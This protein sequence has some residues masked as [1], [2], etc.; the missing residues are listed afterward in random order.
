MHPSE[1]IRGA[2]SD[3]LA[4]MSIVIGITGSIAAVECVKLIRE[5][6][7]HGAIVRAVMTPWAERIVGRDAIEF[8]TGEPV[9]TELTGQVEHVKYCGDV[10]DR[11]DLLLIAPCTANTLGKMVHGI[12]D[13][14]VTTFLTTAI[15]TGIPVMVVPAMHNTMY[16]HPKVMENIETAKQ[17]GIRFVEPVFEEKKAK[18]AGTGVIVEEVLRLL[19]KGRMK[20]QKVLIVTGATVEPIDDMRA[21]TNLATGRTGI[22]LGTE[23]YRNG[24]DV[25]LLAGDNVHSIPEHLEVSRF[26]TVADLISKVELLSNEWA[27]PDM[28]I[29]AAGI[30]DYSPVKVE[31]KLPSGKEN[32]TIEM[33]PTPKVIERFLRLYPDVFTIGYKAESTG[34]NREEL[35]KRA[36]KKLRELSLGL[37]VANDLGDV[38]SDENKVLLITPDKEA[39]RLEGSKE[40]IARFIIDKA[41]ELKG[42]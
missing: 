24:A 32:I 11:A 41:S 5:L 14:P 25:M 26:G 17:M 16:E 23:A 3:R 13:T 28:A 18:M 4:G 19:L 39:F 7:R 33:E 9:I 8:A 1:D 27:V 29:F 38:K 15:G 6:L 34:G 2:R 22:S 30:S 20:G 37:I 10:P 40:D 35:L 36:Y 21:V 42:L 12:D 31:G